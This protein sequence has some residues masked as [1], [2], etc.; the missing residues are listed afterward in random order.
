MKN[1]IFP[2][3]FSIVAIIQFI[4]WALF[5]FSAEFIATDFAVIGGIVILIIS[6][7]VY[8]VIENKV[9]KKLDISRLKFN[10][11]SLIL[12]NIINIIIAI[13]LNILVEKGILSYCSGG[14]WSCFLNGIEYLIFPFFVAIASGV[15]LIIEF[16]YWIY[17]KLKN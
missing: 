4:I 3:I 13:P 14:G 17:R 8:F 6:I 15:I 16:I 10:V 7:V 2:T 11:T 5:V 9:N 12:W 1:K